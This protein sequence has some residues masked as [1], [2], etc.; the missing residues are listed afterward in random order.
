MGVKLW[1]VRSVESWRRVRRRTGR[2]QELGRTRRRHEALLL[3]GACEEQSRVPLLLEAPDQADQDPA[4]GRAGEE[5]A[6]AAHS[7]LRVLHQPRLQFV[8]SFRGELPRNLD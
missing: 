7:L 1:V 6:S 5:V 4:A 3:P 8:H 2:V